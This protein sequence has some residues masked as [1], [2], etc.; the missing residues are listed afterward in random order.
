MLVEGFSQLL[1]DHSQTMNYLASLCFNFYF[2]LVGKEPLRNS[3]N[4]T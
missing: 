2:A 4:F 3:P 1:R